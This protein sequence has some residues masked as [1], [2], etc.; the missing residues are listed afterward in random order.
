M[1]QLGTFEN[2]ITP[3]PI[4][5]ADPVGIKRQSIMKR[6]PTAEPYAEHENKRKVIDEESGAVKE[7]KAGIIFTDRE[8]VDE[9]FTVEEE[10]SALPG[11]ADAGSIPG[12]GAVSIPAV[13]DATSAVS[14]AT[15]AVSSAVSSATSAVSSAVSSAT[16]VLSVGPGGIISDAQKKVGGVLPT[17]GGQFSSSAQAF[18]KDGAS[19]Y[20]KFRRK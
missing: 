17:S 5:P 13:S 7:D 2:L 19:A 12:A 14:S 1:I 9:R 20:N 16:S 11:G 4:D 15:S 8:L 3:D 6:V 10:A 18:G